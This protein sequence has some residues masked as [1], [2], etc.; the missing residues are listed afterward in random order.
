MDAWA[1]EIFDF[2][3]R[4]HLRKVE[5]E[6]SE[7]QAYGF[8]LVDGPTRFGNGAAAREVTPDEMVVEL[9][10]SE[11]EMANAGMANAGESASVGAALVFRE[12]AAADD[13]TGDDGVVFFTTHVQ[14]FLRHDEVAPAIIE[15][16][17]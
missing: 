2:D 16:G 17:Q 7:A 8:V 12:P 14:E 10:E 11:E 15:E 4:A 13:G 9:P 6:P 1:R 5:H 3:T